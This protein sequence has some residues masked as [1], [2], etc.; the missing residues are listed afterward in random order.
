M[1]ERLVVHSLNMPID[2][3]L[4]R[5]D[6]IP[7]LSWMVSLTLVS[8]VKMNFEAV[9]DR[10]ALKEPSEFRTLTPLVDFGGCRLSIAIN[11]DE[12]VNNGPQDT[13]WQTYCDHLPTTT[14][15]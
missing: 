9:P 1:G 13:S 6:D 3:L 2:L 10:V 8:S 15:A 12:V 5:D 11:K 14:K 4:A 7:V